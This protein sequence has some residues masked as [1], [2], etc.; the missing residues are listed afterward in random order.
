MVI[1]VKG[2]HCAT[3]ALSISKGLFKKEGVSK[4]DVNYGTE[5][6]VVEY[7]PE[8]ISL[9]EIGDVIRELEYEPVLPT[10]DKESEITLQIV[11]MTCAACVAAVEKALERINGVNNVVVSLAT[12]KAYVKYDA[13]L[14]SIVELREAVRS[15]GYDVSDEEETDNYMEEL[16]KVKRRMLTSWMFT[17]PIILWMFPHM[18]FGIAWPSHF[19]FQMGITVLSAPA[20]FWVGWP[21]IRSAWASL[22]HGS[23]NMD[24]LIAMGT[25]IAWL[26]GP[27]SFV[28]PLFNYAGTSSMILSFHLT[29]RYYEALAKGQSSQAIR[30]LLKMEAKS[31]FILVD[32]EEK[33]IALEQIEVGN[34]MIVKPGEKI[35]TDG[36]VVKGESSVDESMATGES[37]PVTK[38]VGD[39]MIGATVNQEG[40]LH[41]EATRIGKDTFLS[42]IIKMVEEAQGTKV[43]IQKFADD[44]I[45][46][47][48]PIVI[49]VAFLTLIGWIVVP[50]PF[51]AV[52]RWGAPSL[53]WVDVN[54]PQVMLAISAMISVLV[55]ACPCSLGLAT[56]TT[57]MVGTGMG[58]RNG[59]LIRRGEAIQTMKAIKAVILDKTG[60]ITKGQPAITDVVSNGMDDDELFR[61]AASL[62]QGSEHPLA[63]AIIRSAMQKGI[64]LS[65]PT[66]FKAL[67][68]EGVIGKVG[69]DEVIVGKPSLLSS[70]PETLLNEFSRLQKEAKTV[71][72]VGVNG[73]P[74]GI[75]AV[76]DTL[77]E[78]SVPAIKEL[79]RMGLKTIMLTGD[80]RATAEAIARQVGIS[81]VYPDVM[82][83][84]KV[85]V[86]IEA[87][88][89]HGMVAM[90]G[91]GI[92]DAPA[93]AQANVGVAIGTGTDI[94]I[95]SG[96][97]ILVRGDLTGLVTA[98]NLS[99]ATFDKIRQNLFWAFFYNV[100]SI[101]LAVVGFL[102]PVIAESAMAMSS[103]TVVTNANLLR[104]ARIKP[105]YA[106]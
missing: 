71:M 31:A 97:I 8:K 32:D 50:V 5:K 73:K 49:G 55:I 51:N 94:A 56:P 74:A 27:A 59:I 70:F 34:I 88:E 20:V 17:G 23:A 83:D 96:D 93:L 11:G 54:L 13:K 29:G 78:D 12:E 33:E 84:E 42:Q 35:P 6:A 15:Q 22:T 72:A 101:P 18:V 1:P 85:R 46:I 82:P 45:A 102:H 10:D 92:N 103:I 57:L 90:V 48:V 38:G 100:I 89:K 76:A 14:V 66:D 37:M 91:D 30:Q 65:Q 47:F 106:A 104:R 80:N 75:I 86:V 21:T 19:I 99:K 9:D 53:P 63:K 67:R 69:D 28:T 3:C 2:M 36:V 79:G 68:G 105:E 62:E 87:Q 44:V 98:I 41:I 25:I 43:P 39:E 58:A 60:T 64:K 24:V 77:K 16:G 61:Y 81:E 95:E 4:A 40:L 7:D 52:L 26:T